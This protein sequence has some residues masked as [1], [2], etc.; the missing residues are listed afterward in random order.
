MVSAGLRVIRVVVMVISS[1]LYV[2]EIKWVY[3]TRVG[4][5]VSTLFYVAGRPESSLYR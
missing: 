3:F 4:R 5:L 2:C 1:F